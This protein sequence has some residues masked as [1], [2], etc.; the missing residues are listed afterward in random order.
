VTLTSDH[1]ILECTGCDRFLK[2]Y[3]ISSASLAKNWSNTKFK[4][5]TVRDIDPPRSSSYLYR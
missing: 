4:P 1:L 3:T 2:G 5:D